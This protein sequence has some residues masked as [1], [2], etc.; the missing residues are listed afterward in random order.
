MGRGS[1][2][3]AIAGISGYTGQRALPLFGEDARF[4]LRPS[5]AKKPPWSEDRRTIGVDLLDEAALEKVLAEH[6]VETIVCLVGTT[7]AQFQPAKNGEHEVSYETVDVGIPRALANAGKRAGAK[8][9]VLLSSAGIDSGPGAYADAKRRAEK[10]VRDSGL[11]WTIIR[12]SFIVGPGRA[13]AKALDVFWAPVKLFSRGTAD[14]WRSIDATDLAK[15]VV[16]VAR[17]SE[18]DGQI[19]HGR[20][21]HALAK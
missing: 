1:G 2:S 21:L 18:H 6:Q 4:L 15:A 14:D 10:A 5:T 20:A 8:R 17:S 12:P 11:A 19:L 16:A 3:I 13:A 9:F 7:K